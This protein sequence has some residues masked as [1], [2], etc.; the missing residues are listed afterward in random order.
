MKDTQRQLSKL[1]RDFGDGL[2]SLRQDYQQSFAQ[3]TQEHKSQFDQLKQ[4]TDRMQI[5]IRSVD[6]QVKGL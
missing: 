6:A 3:F 5:Q 2:Q 1:T 4:D